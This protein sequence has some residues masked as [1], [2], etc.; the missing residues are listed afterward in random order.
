MI[1]YQLR[2][3]RPDE[4]TEIPVALLTGLLGALMDGN[5]RAL[6]LRIE[7]FSTRRGAVPHWLR[8]AASFSLVGVRSGSIVLD[9]E[10][11]PLRQMLPFFAL[12]LLD[13]GAADR[14]CVA[15]FA[16]SLAAALSAREEDVLYDADLLATFESL[17]GIF[18]MGVE[19]IELMLDPGTKDAQAVV[20]AEDIGRLTW[21]SGRSRCGPTRAHR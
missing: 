2:L 16:E 8:E 18:A 6:R 10:A 20:R 14:P 15:L 9:F 7:G 4:S 12:G 19:R 3:V 13:A 17:S 11:P 5:L 21:T 1:R